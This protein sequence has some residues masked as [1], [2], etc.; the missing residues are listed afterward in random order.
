M[1]TFKHELVSSFTH[2]NINFAFEYSDF[3]RTVTFNQY[4]SKMKL[5]RQSLL[6][7]YRLDQSNGAPLNPMGRTGLL[8]KGLLPRWGPNHTIVLCIT[9]WSRDTRTGSQ[10]LRSNRGVLQYL[11]LERNKRLCMP[12][13]RFL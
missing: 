7:R 12:W 6:G 10:V 13:V 9:R 3:L 2:G 4:D 8:G 1:F 5:R 11:A